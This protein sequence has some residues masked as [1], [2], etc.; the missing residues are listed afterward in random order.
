MCFEFTLS[1]NLGIGEIASKDSWCLGVRLIVLKKNP[2][3]RFD[4]IDVRIHIY[5]KMLLF[6]SK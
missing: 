5:F 2:G 3:T 6:T 1:V 4:F